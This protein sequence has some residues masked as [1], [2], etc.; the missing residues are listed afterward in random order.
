MGLGDRI[1]RALLK[2]TCD[3]A[4][5]NRAVLRW[6]R[7]FA[8]AAAVLEPDRRKKKT[9]GALHGKKVYKRKF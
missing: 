5:L 7:Y 1:R 3:K 8:E 9:G 2:A 4:E 6:R